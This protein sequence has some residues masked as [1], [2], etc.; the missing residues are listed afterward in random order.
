[1]TTI[2]VSDFRQN[3]AEYLRQVNQGATL[4]I[5]DDKKNEN[6]AQ[7]TPPG[8]RKL[9]PN[10]YKAMLKRVAGTF[11][12]KSHPEWATKAKVEKWLRTSRLADERK[13]DVYN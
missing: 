6:L 5:K 4:M 13:S 12:A 3:I 8:I 10:A 2:S 1:M 7:L 9:D 11:T